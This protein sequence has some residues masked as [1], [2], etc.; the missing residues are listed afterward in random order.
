ALC[1]RETRGSLRYLLRRVLA[2]Y[3]DQ[4]DEVGQLGKDARVRG[5]LRRRRIEEAVTIRLAQGCHRRPHRAGRE[6]LAGNRWRVPGGDE[7]QGP[8]VCGEEIALALR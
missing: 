2:E 1:R 4:Q 5:G 6:V 8:G 3:D 7:V